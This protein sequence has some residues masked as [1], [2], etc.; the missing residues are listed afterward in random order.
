MGNLTTEQPTIRVNLYVKQSETPKLFDALKNI[1]PRYRAEAV[2]LA[3]EKNSTLLDDY[4]TVK[5]STIDISDKQESKENH[6][7]T[8]DGNKNNDNDFYGFM[9][10]EL[11]D[12]LS[13]QKPES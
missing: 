2:R 5:A 4:I 9:T 7:A 8:K 10:P 13:I 6:A 11:V 3:L 1:R 12:K